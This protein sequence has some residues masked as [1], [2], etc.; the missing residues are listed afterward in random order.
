MSARAS[1]VHVAAL[2]EVAL[3]DALAT[4]RLS[5]PAP[6]GAVAATSGAIPERLKR[7]S[8]RVS[9]RKFEGGKT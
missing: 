4:L 3:R 2:G 8:R 9:K 1:F 7:A 5:P 6:P